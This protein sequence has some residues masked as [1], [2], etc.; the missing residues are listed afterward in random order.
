MRKRLAAAR[1]AGAKRP[2]AVVGAFHA[3]ALIRGDDPPGAG[4]SGKAEVVTS[5]IPYAFE[6]LDSRSG[7]PAGIRDP[8]WQQAVLASGGTAEAISES[9]TDFAVRITRELR[10]HGHPAGVPDSREVVH[11][12][13]DL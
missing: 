8:E 2:V 9:C 12:A 7:Y 13:A 4:E 5:L 3:A 6:L 11:E 10:A 1:L